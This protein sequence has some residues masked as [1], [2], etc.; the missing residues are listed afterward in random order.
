MNDTTM[1]IG[2]GA[3]YV[4]CVDSMYEVRSMEYDY[5]YGYEHGVSFGDIVCVWWMYF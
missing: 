1:V 4:F 5:G 2:A 3:S